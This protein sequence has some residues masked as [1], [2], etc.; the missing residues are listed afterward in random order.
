MDTC[1]KISIL[2]SLAYGKTVST[3]DV[4]CEGITKITYDDLVFAR[5][6]GYSIKLLG[7]ASKEDD[8]KVYVITAPF[9]VP[10]EN[11]LSTVNDVYNGISV[12][13]NVVGDVLFCGRGAGS[14][15]TA[16]AVMAD[17]LDVVRD[18]KKSIGW[19]DEKADFLGDMTCF[20]TSNYIRT[21]AEENTIKTVFGAVNVSNRNG[22]NVFITE[23]IKNCELLTKLEK[24]SAEW[25]RIRV[26]Q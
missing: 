25:V 9:L 16:S 14:L 19:K 13:G 24:L 26:M 21:K 2:S 15:P 18:C 4:I 8:G 6:N 23:Q 12:V 1:R 17:V 3:E 7:R 20:A 11:A 10:K 22:W 5:E